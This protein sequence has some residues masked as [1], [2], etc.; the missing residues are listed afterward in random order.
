MCGGGYSSLSR[1]VL[2]NKTT[3]PRLAFEGKGGEVG[4]R[5]LLKDDNDDDRRRRRLEVKRKR[6]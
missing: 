3:H 2:K 5:T 6:N 4:R 1:G